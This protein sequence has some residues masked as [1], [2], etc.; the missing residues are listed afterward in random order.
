MV[1]FQIASDLHIEVLK[2]IPNMHNYIEPKAEI[3]I[4][5]GDIGRVTK[6]EQL[7][8]FINIVCSKF[9]IVLYV[10]GNH[11]FY[12]VEGMEEKSMD[13]ILKMVESLKEDNKNLYILNRMSVIIEDV[14]ITGCTLWSKCIIQLPSYIVKIPNMDTSKYNHLFKKDYN[15]LVDMTKYCQEKNLKLLVVTHHCPSFDLI[16]RKDD[17]NSCL[18][19]SNLDYLFLKEK[20]H[21]WIFGHSHKNC[22]Y[23]TPG[24]TRLVCNQ[25]GKFKEEARYFSKSKLIN[26]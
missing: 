5:A 10:L 6:F 22:D 14:C 2:D 26:V 16:N 4:L 25:R 17:K 19:A 15:Y 7:K 24:G 18:Y 20:I 13:E 23:I 21:T 12:K 11:E 1:L 3:L 8:S 9:K